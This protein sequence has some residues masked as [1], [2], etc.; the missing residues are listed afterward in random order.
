MQ[1]EFMFKGIC[2]NEGGGGDETFSLSQKGGGYSS[3]YKIRIILP[4]KH[5]Y[6]F[7]RLFLIQIIL[8]F[9]ACVD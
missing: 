8:T 7:A 6:I 9:D 5:D 4:V 3:S 1:Y 2:V